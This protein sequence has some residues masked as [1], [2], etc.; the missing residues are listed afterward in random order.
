MNVPPPAPSRSSPSAY[1][2]AR[3]DGLAAA[4]ADV[5]PPVVACQSP[6]LRPAMIK[7]RASA[8]AAASL[9]APGAWSTIIPPVV[10]SIRAPPL[11]SSRQA[12]E[13]DSLEAQRNLILAYV[14]D[15]LQ[16]N[17]SRLDFYE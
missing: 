1:P 17:S 16:L 5:I 14:R 13:G 11:S 3:P 8:I 15:Y 4:A 7:P 6:E 9:P 2:T 12:N 10:R